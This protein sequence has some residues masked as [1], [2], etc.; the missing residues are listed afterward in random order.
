MKRGSFRISLKHFAEKIGISYATMRRVIKDLVSTNEIEV[1]IT[2]RDTIITV[3]N[4][5]KYQGNGI[6]EVKK[7]STQKTLLD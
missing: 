2:N 5:E 6:P 4:Y 1:T 3:L 7:V